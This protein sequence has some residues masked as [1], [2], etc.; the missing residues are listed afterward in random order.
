MPQ[1]ICSPHQSRVEPANYGCLN[2]PA[3]RVSVVCATHE[4]TGLLGLAT[5]S[6]IGRLDDRNRIPCP[7][8]RKLDNVVAQVQPEI[9]RSSLLRGVPGTG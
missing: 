1:F 5:A 8:G 4:D 2:A 9:S 3:D 6:P 7:T